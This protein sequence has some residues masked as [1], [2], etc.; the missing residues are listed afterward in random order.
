MRRR[1]SPSCICWS[2]ARCCTH[3]EEAERLGGGGQRGHRH[4]H[5]LEDKGHQQLH[6]QQF[7]L[8]QSVAEPLQNGHMAGDDVGKEEKLLQLIDERV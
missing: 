3:Q 8:S 4:V 5:V 6:A 7:Q 2:A 1:N